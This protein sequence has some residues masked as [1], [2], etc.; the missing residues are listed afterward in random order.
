MDTVPDC[1]VC[2]LSK[3]ALP[4][5]VSIEQDAPHPMWNERLFEQE[6]LHG[7]S[8]VYG[9]RFEGEL[10][11]FL[12]CHAVAEEA[13]I[14]NVV[15]RKSVRGKGQGKGFLLEVI[16]D[17]HCRGVRQITLE[18]RQ[19]NT[20]ARSLYESVGFVRVGVRKGYY[21]DNGEDA[22]VMSL[23]VPQCAL[24]FQGLS[25]HQITRNSGN[26]SLESV[27]PLSG[28]KL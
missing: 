4:D 27:P 9:L 6:F 10:A 15:L 18:V 20:I 3:R 22:L 14:L 5:L 19:S 21:S 2:K 25:F 7:H 24:R 8:C 13:H 26:V 28:E 23:D 12:I 1:I 11:G 17:L 16:Q